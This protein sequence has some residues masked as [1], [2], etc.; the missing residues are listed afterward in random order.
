MRSSERS[1]ASAWRAIEA[2]WARQRRTSMGVVDGEAGG[3][4]GVADV[5]IQGDGPHGKQGLEGIAGMQCCDGVH[6]VFVAFRP[7]VRGVGDGRG[8][9]PHRRAKI[10]QRLAARASGWGSSEGIGAWFLWG[11]QGKLVLRET[12]VNVR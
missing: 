9:S 6:R 2:A 10:S 11:N 8:S 1:A 12:K 7:E 4:E 5:G 3:A